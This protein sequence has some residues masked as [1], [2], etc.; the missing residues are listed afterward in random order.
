MCEALVQGFTCIFS[1]SPAPPIARHAS[2]SG[3]LLF[4]GERPAFWSH[5]QGAARLGWAVT[6]KPV[7]RPRVHGWGPGPSCPP[8]L[9]RSAFIYKMEVKMTRFI[10]VLPGFRGLAH[11]RPVLRTAV[12][13]G[14]AA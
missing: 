5:A 1:S 11:V 9:D 7:L 12:G 2:S 3:R 10:G 13:T 14:S 4:N 8:R 6:P